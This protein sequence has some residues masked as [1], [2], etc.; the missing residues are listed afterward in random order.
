MIRLGDRDVGS[1][2]PALIIAELGTSHQG[3][4]SRARWLID[5]AVEAGAD[6]VKFQL[7]YAQ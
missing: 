1:G 5:A 7:V 3:N 4:L 2:A 6:C